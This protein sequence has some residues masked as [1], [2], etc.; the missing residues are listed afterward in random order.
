[1]VGS[2]AGN[3]IYF[4]KTVQF[5]PGKGNPVQLY[6]SIFINTAVYG[7]PDGFR[8][9][10]DLFKHEMFIAFLLCSIHI[11]GY[12]EN[13]PL[14]RISVFVENLYAFR[15]YYYHLTV[16]DEIDF[17]DIFKKGRDIGSNKIAALSK[18]C[19]KGC[20]LSY[21]H[22]FVGIVGGNGHN[23]IGSSHAPHSL[24]YSIFEAVTLFHVKADQMC[25]HLRI[26]FG[27]EM[28]MVLFNEFF[29]Q[30]HKVFNDTVVDDCHLSVLAGVRMSVDIRRRPVGC[31]ASM[32]YARMA[33]K[34]LPCNKIF[35][36]F[37]SP[38]MLLYF[39]FPVNK[40][41]DSCRIIAAIFKFFQTVY[42]NVPGIIPACISY[43]TTHNLLPF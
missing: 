1:M 8:L 6:H 37:Y 12:M 25:H 38:H 28:H 36:V 30:L 42:D 18:T 43:N 19:N 5:F 31:P 9:L 4:G 3:Y 35:Q 16:F 32:S 14:Y 27:L 17:L 33:V 26:S 29:L 10:K 21:G 2:S 11:P 34:V 7:F 39:Y 23:G 15:G 24:I 13:L 41:G 40:Q 22:Q 20:V